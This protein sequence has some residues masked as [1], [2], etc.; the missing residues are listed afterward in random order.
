MEE[1]EIWNYIIKW[2]IAQNSGLPSDPEYWSHEN[3]SALKTT[4]QN[5]LPHISF[6]Q[7]SGDDIINNVQPY[8]QIFEKKLWKDIMKKYMANEPISSTVLPPRIILKPALPTRIIETF[9]KV[10]NETHAAQIASWID[11]KDD[12]YLVMDIP[13]E[14]KLLI[15]GSRDGFTAA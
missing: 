4:L 5:C 8:Q 1:V 11:K 12:T 14:F 2:G 3:F 6:F 7:M 9:S 10:I 15:C 13:Y